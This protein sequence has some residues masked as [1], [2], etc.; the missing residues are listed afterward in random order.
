MISGRLTRSRPRR[1]KPAASSRRA[2]VRSVS[3]PEATV[4]ITSKTPMNASSVQAMLSGIPWSWAGGTKW[5]Y[6]MPFVEAPQMANT[7]TNRSPWS[8]WPRGRR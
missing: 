3:R 5:V 7:W 8:T 6:T 4:P 1:K 2:S